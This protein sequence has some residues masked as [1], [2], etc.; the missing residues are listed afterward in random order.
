MSKIHA[1]T[2]V[3]AISKDLNYFLAVHLEIVSTM[4]LDMDCELEHGVPVAY[5]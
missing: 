2:R 3:D 4:L 1:V 5:D